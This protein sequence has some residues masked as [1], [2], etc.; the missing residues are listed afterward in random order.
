MKHEQTPVF[1]DDWRALPKEYQAQFRAVLK[2]K[3]VPACDRRA[4]NPGEVWPAAL[5]VKPMKRNGD[6][7]EMTWSFSN[8]DGR[9]TFQ[10]IEV[11]GE[12]RIRWRRIGLHDVLNNP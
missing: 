6:I 11:D 9:A 1:D 7:L 3:F 10:W 12:P 5:R 8:P 2:D 4:G